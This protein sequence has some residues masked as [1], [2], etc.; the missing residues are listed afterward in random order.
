MKELFDEYFA[1]GVEMV[2]MIL[3]ITVLSDIFSAVLAM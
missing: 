3:L 2:I 1:S